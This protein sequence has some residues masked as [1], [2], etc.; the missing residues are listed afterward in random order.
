MN[1][2]ARTTYLCR[3][4]WRSRSLRQWRA[5]CSGSTTLALSEADMFFRKPKTVVCAAC[6]KPIEPRERR[7][8]DK[9]RVT[10][11]SGIP[12]SIAGGRRRHDTHLTRISQ[13]GAVDLVRVAFHP[14]RLRLPVRER[15]VVFTNRHLDL[16]KTLLIEYK[17][18]RDDLVEAEEK[19][20]QRVYLIGFERSLSTE[21]HPAIDVV[22]D[23][24][25]K[26]CAYRQDPAPFP[27]LD[28]WTV[29]RFQLGSPASGP[30]RPVAGHAPL[31]RKE[32]RAFL[33]RA[34]ARREFRSIRTDGDIPRAYFLRG[35][36][37][38]DTILGRRLRQH[39]RSQKESS[40][41]HTRE[42]PKRCAH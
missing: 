38:S 30:V 28:A 12:T 11:S 41:E 26:R 27:R 15:R 21:R 29:L 8:V 6:G 40:Q 20:R 7:F 31:A 14:A 9:N 25:R 13:V 22:P 37:C 36:R 1:A 5:A 34:A 10:K 33:G 16:R 3:R 17:V 32:L 2:T 35:R 24:R 19:R 39:G 42:K 4:M 23:D 18:L